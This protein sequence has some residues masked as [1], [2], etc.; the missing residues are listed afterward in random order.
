[1]SGLL[2]FLRLYYVHQHVFRALWINEAGAG[3]QCPVFPHSALAE[4]H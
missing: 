3:P 1:M 2:S 4:G